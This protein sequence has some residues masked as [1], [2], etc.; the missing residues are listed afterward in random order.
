MKA[1]DTIRT[2]LKINEFDTAL[3]EDM[4]DAPLT[5]PTSKGGNHPLW[6]VGHLALTEATFRE[7]ITGEPNDLQKWKPLFDAGTQPQANASL[8]PDFD[9]VLKEY[10]KQRARN[11]ELLEELGENGLA[12]PPNAPPQEMPAEFA[13]ALFQTNGH[14]FLT[15]ATH[16]SFH[17][18]QAA[19]ARRAAGRKPLMM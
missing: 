13:D 2:A 6:I 3:F 15:M 4:R 14:A 17:S 18:G 12:Q 7:M 16:H 5:Q 8:Y 9:D 1:I 11:M 19:D 10:G